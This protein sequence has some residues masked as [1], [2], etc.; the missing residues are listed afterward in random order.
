MVILIIDDELGL[1]RNLGAFLED[2]DHTVLE[3]ADGQA[4]LEVLRANRDIIEAVFVDLRM[5]IMDGY[6]FLQHAVAEAPELPVIVLSGVDVLSEA[7]KTMRLGAWDFLTKPLLE[8]EM[9]NHVLQTV[10]ERARLLRENR[11]QKEHLEKL[12][13]ELSAAQSAAESANKMKSQFLASMSHEIRTP[14]S[15]L[16]GMLHLLRE[17]SLDESQRNYLDSAVTASENLR[18]LV[19]DILDLSRIEAGKMELVEAVFVPCQTI[20]DV[21]SSLG[22]L[23]RGKGLEFNLI[24]PSDSLHLLGDSQRVNQVVVNLVGNAIKFTQKGRVTVNVSLSDVEGGSK[25]LEVIVEDTGIGIDAEKVNTVFDAFVQAHSVSTMQG[26]GLGL[27]ISR[28]LA[29]AMGGDITVESIPGQG[30]VFKFFAQLPVPDAESIAAYEAACEECRIHVNPLAEIAPLRILIAEDFEI[31]REYLLQI[32]AKAGHETTV[33][34][35]GAEAVECA[36]REQFDLILMDIQMPVMN[37]IEAAKKI[38]G[39]DDKAKAATP[40]V[41]LTAFAF[42]EEKDA[43]MAAGMNGHL[44]KPVNIRE[45]C[46]M[47]VNLMPDKVDAAPVKSEKVSVEPERSAAQDTAPHVEIEGLIQWDT[48]LKY[49]NGDETI[50]YYFCA[51]MMERLA[52]EIAEASKALSSQDLDVFT[53]KVHSFKSLAASLGADGLASKCAAAEKAGTARDIPQVTS[54]FPD[55]EAD[56]RRMLQEIFAHFDSAKSPN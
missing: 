35:N 55:I 46:R 25:K 49:M 40:I 24:L 1:R 21:L 45:L 12:V 11:Q 50:L 37:G 44:S 43:I 8:M 3:A 27:S 41:A 36:Q 28:S 19:N 48:A 53:R 10:T 47:I 6:T 39:F 33:A 7:L 26:T 34:E 51:K 38:R 9:V 54:L 18:L 13:Q 22:H 17:T 29:R 5:P 20:A 23:A 4:G 14:L 16:V 52:G 30:S 56:L 2:R 32:L 31:V 15:G 42:Q